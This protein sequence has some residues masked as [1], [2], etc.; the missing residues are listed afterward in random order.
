MK[1]STKLLL[2]ILFYLCFCI[3][4]SIIGANDVV[5]STKIDSVWSSVIFTI[6]V[7]IPLNPFFSYCKVMSNYYCLISFEIQ[8]QG[9]KLPAFEFKYS[10]RRGLMRE[11][12][13]RIHNLKQ[14]GLEQFEKLFEQ[15]YQKHNFYAIRS[16][17][18]K[19]QFIYYFNYG[20]REALL[21]PAEYFQNLTNYSDGSKQLNYVFSHYYIECDVN[22]ITKIGFG[23]GQLI[24]KNQG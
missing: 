23:K 20:F 17:C 19:G 16:G 4:A 9:M 24:H 10:D 14:N 7:D 22:V 6:S 2:T 8:Y 13:E 21:T 12:Y 15:I 18:C 5:V 1:R 3:S 11:F